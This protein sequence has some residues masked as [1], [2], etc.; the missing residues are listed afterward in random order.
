MLFIPICHFYLKQGP[1]GMP[2]Q[3]FISRI[4]S[5]SQAHMQMQYPSSTAASISSLS[6]LQPLRPNEQQQLPDPKVTNESSDI[7]HS[8]QKQPSNITVDK[9][10]DDGYNWRK[11]GQKQVKG[12]EFPRSYYKCTHPNCP[13]KKKVERSLDGQITEIIYKGQHNH[14][15]PSKRTRDT[16]P[17]M[18]TQGNSEFGSEEGRP[19]LPDA[20]DQ[21]SSQVTP[22]NVSGSS[23]GDGVGN[24]ETRRD[25]RD[26]DEPDFK[27]RYIFHYCYLQ[28]I[29]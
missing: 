3:Q 11:Y 9:P 2:H 28:M 23:E 20:K 22:E 18:N 26:E 1:F 17:P 27:R 14:P 13:V 15:Q 10:T 6:H 24:A 7:S 29:V 21:V 25:E 8:D 12:S 5:R 19:Y 4:Q 16:A